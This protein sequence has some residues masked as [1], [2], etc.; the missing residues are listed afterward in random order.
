M[1]AQNAAG[2]ATSIAGPL[3]ATYP[4]PAALG[5]L[6]EEVFDEGTGPQLVETEVAFEG[7]DLTFTV[8][9]PAA[10]AGGA[11]ID[12]RTGVLA[13]PTER[14]VSGGRVTVIAA[15]SGGAAR[16][17]LRF[18]VEQAFG[19]AALPVEAAPRTLGAADVA[20][21][22]CVWRPAG[23]GVTFTPLARLPGLA[24]ETV[25]GVEWTDAP[26]DAPDDAPEYLP[27]AHWRPA[28]PK[29]GEA[30]VYEIFAT[31][32]PPP[33]G[34]P[35]PA[36]FRA[37]QTDRRLRFRWRALSEG[38]WSDP[39][40]AFEVPLPSAPPAV[41]LVAPTS[42]MLQ[43]AML[44]G[45]RLRGFND[46][47]FLGYSQKDN[48]YQSTCVRDKKRAH[49][50]TI[51]ALAAW[52]GHTAVFGGRTAAQRA[53]E[54]LTAWATD[55]A[56]AARGGVG[57][58]CDLM[59]A[60]CAALG[61][62]T[63]AVWDAVAPEDRTRIDRAMEGLLVS[64]A[65]QNSDNNPFVKA[66]KRGAERTITGGDY[67]RS[68]VPN[69]TCAS[70]LMPHVV[71]AY[72]GLAGAQDFLAGFDRAEFA[73]GIAAA[74]ANG[75]LDDL[76]ATFDRD[77]TGGPNGP[78][79]TAAE[80]ATAIRQ[81]PDGGPYRQFGWGLADATASMMREIDKMW[82][83]RVRAGIDP[84]TVRRVPPG[85]EKRAGEVGVF[86]QA[87]N[88]ETP[89]T[90]PGRDAQ[91]ARLYDMAA[92]AAHAHAGMSGMATEL[93]TTDGGA[94][95]SGGGP[96]SS[97]SYAVEGCSVV[98]TACAVLAA[99]NQLDRSGAAL[100]TA[101]ARQDRGVYDL[102]FRSVHG[103]RSFAK[104]GR[105]WAGDGTNSDWDASEAASLQMFEL[106][107]VWD[108]QLKLWAPV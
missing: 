50:A 63:P 80:L 26:D 105:L 35:D 60:N 22:C 54:Q 71:V 87:K 57:M 3:R 24:G 61:R 106:F 86:E 90:A 103:H 98:L 16:V 76:Q 15:N 52:A 72:M 59:F 108:L 81:G 58:Q 70:V 29:A 66:G 65:W 94:N 53:A 47:D 20:I 40:V 64:A 23:Q 32:R 7:A 2:A 55:Q 88:P 49:L 97:M 13:I 36:L 27:E 30:G 5:D 34:D 9:G 95:G 56:P 4:A 100:R 37:D 51:V 79:P 99:L 21:L 89:N 46:Y 67:A 41:A 8:M 1:T 107:D 11:A 10:S 69:F 68:R 6:P 43:A 42:A 38:P 45:A 83:A 96:R 18:T 17:R 74:N 73:A 91:V 25:E 12:P 93:D 84:A 78:G 19:E 102:R 39:S 33:A 92:Y 82:G 101:F 14:P 28:R 31:G 77:W 104:G 48:P 75:A 44:N 62:A 85:V